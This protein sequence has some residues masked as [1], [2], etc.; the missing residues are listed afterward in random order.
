MSD[1]YEVY[2]LKYGTRANRTRAD[3]FLMDAHSATPHTIDYFV[4][5]I[6]NAD[7]TIVVDT[8]YDDA[9]ARRRGRP[10]FQ[11]P[12]ACLADFGIA[13][14]A[15]DTV[16]VTHLHYDHAGTLGQ[17]P[18]AKFHLQAAEMAYATGPCMCQ[19]YL[20]EPF[21]GEHVCEM[22]RNV[23]SGKV[24]F[25]DG[26]GE[27]APGITVH[28]MGGHSRGLQSVRVKTANGHMMLASD[29][30]HFYENFLMGR[31][32]PI[33]VD[34]SQMLTGFTRLKQ[35]ASSIDLVVPGHDPLVCEFF[36][37]VA[38]DEAGVFRL[39]AGP[40]RTIADLYS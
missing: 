40:S 5:V 32:F 9:E 29:A 17:F 33:V 10:I 19:D 15:I 14:E 26:D 28:A 4:W 18:N 36:P 11:S 38:G 8:G 2:A 20:R 21:T 23:F 25:H 39:D 12:A 1:T 24:I 31:I 16:I 7:R 37:K 22:V 35:L 34:S 3:S 6:R 13:A 27:I 30:S